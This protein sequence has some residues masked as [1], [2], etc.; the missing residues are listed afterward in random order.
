MLFV[1]PTLKIILDLPKVKVRFRSVYGERANRN[2]YLWQN[3]LCTS[4]VPKYWPYLFAHCLL[5]FAVVGVR[6]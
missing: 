6:P 4:F 3:Y 5:T 2:I 1:F